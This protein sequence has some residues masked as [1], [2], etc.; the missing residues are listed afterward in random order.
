MLV[1][2]I[3]WIFLCQKNTSIPY[4]I[5][6]TYL[7]LLPALVSCFEEFSSCVKTG[8]EL[9]LN[10]SVDA[11]PD[12]PV[13]MEMISIATGTQAGLEVTVELLSVMISV[14]TGTKFKLEETVELLSIII[15]EATDIHA[16][17]EVTAELLPVDASFA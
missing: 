17:P 2:Q 1:F 8:T 9:P 11:C 13:G 10:L 4:T 7:S 16:E 12:E 14:E 5:T 6:I 3:Q 15:S